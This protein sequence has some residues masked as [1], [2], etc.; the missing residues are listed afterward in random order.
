MMLMARRSTLLGRPVPTRQPPPRHK[1]LLKFQLKTDFISTRHISVLNSY[2]WLLAPHQ[3]TD[4]HHC[5]K[6]YWSR[7]S[8]Q[9]G[10][11]TKNGSPHQKVHVSTVYLLIKPFSLMPPFKPQSKSRDWSSPKL[12]VPYPG[13]HIFPGNSTSKSNRVPTLR[14]SSRPVQ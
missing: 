8:Q 7:Q 4:I 13:V 5:R 3:M 11:K 12:Q 1:W 9:T 14:A 2:V 6:C 10:K